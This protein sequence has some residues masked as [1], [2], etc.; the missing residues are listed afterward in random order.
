MNP[1]FGAHIG[2]FNCTSLKACSAETWC[3]NIMYAHT[4]AADLDCPIAQCTK[5]TLSLVPSALAINSFVV[6]K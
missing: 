4:I 2:L 1:S 5:T 6:L 3:V